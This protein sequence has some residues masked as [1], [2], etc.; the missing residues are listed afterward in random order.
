MGLLDEL[1]G[2]DTEVFLKLAGEMLWIVET[3]LFG[4]FSNGGPANK[5]LLGTLHQE[6][7]DVGGGGIARQFAYEVAEVVG[8]E[9]KLLGTVFHGGQSVLALQVLGI[10]LTEQML[11]AGQQVGVR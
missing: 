3:E 5:Q 10:V 11:K 9:E 7:T 2:G 6:A 8:R 1:R 4:G